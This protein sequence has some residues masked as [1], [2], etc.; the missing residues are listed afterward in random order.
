M[1]CNLITQTKQAMSLLLNGGNSRSSRT[2][3]ILEIILKVS[4]YESLKPALSTTLTNLEL[5]TYITL[6]EV[7]HI[8]TNNADD[9]FWMYR[10]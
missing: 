2:Q 5:Y 9:V 3:N 6:G 7:P 4:N 8:I 1:L 10:M